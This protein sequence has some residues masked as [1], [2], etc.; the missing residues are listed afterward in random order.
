MKKIHILLF[1]LFSVVFAHGSFALTLE[2]KLANPEDETRA[3]EIFQQ[4]RCVVCSGESIADS[5]AE[6]AGELR[7]LVRGKIK[8]GEA[9]NAIINYIADKYGDDILMQ[10]PL[11]PSTYMLWFGP[12]IILLGGITIALVKL[13][14]NSR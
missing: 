3:V 11:K 12:F 8:S 13:N 1:I 10:P 4:I 7:A 5:R 6:L 9:S 14:K 2:E